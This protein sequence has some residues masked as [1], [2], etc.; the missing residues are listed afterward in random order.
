M[1]KKLTDKAITRLKLKPRAYAVWDSKATGLGV[2]VT[3]AGRRLWV[4]Q[5]RYPGH[6]TQSRRTLGPYPAISLSA[7]RAKAAEWYGWVRQGIDPADA[8]AER[9]QAAQALQRAR[10]LET[11]TTFASVANRYVNEHLAKQ[12]RAKRAAAEMRELTD[13]WGARPIAS[14]T[15]SDVKSLINKIKTRAPYQARNAFGHARTLFKFAVHNDLLAVS[16]CA[17]LEQRWVLSGAQLGPRQRVLNDTEIAALWRAAGRLGYPYGPLYRLL[18]LTGVRVNELARARW[19]EFHPE[20][21]KIIRGRQPI[22]W[23]DV[24]DTTK[25]WTIP[26]ERFKSDA[27]HVVPLSDDACAILATLPRFSGDLLFTTTGG[28]KP[29]NGLSKA[30]ERLDKR[31]LLTLKAMARSRGEDPHTVTLPEFINHDLR[32]VVRTNLSA[33]DVADHIAEIVLGHGRKGLQ[34]VYDQ[35]R[36]LPQTRATLVL[37]AARLRTIVAPPPPAS[38]DRVVAFRRGGRRR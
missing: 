16:P 18:L 36:Y 5:L 3:P 12:R 29:I 9:Q 38:P 1:A 15:P 10:A 26:R 28:E 4:V 7:A 34:R 8:E 37:W 25:V 19:S 24:P 11:A 32:R 30:K 13:A 27:E 17:S 2:K 6:R 21:R 23:A 14:I 20:L 31:M 22:D 35:H 33:L